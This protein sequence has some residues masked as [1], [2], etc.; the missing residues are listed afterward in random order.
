[1]ISEHFGRG[2]L[3]ELLSLLTFANLL[4]KEG[5]AALRKSHFS[6]VPV[7]Q[8]D[9]SNYYVDQAESDADALIV[10]SA[11]AASQSFDL[12][13]NVAEYIDI[14]ALL[15]ALGCDTTSAAYNIGKM[16]FL[17][18]LQK[19]PDLASGVALFSNQRVNCSLL[20]IVAERF[21]IAVHGGSRDDSLDGLRYKRFANHGSGII[22]ILKTG[23]G[24][25]ENDFEDELPTLTPLH[26]S[27]F[28]HD[29]ISDAEI[30]TE[31]QP[32]PSKKLKTN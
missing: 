24:K 12:V 25:K 10:R 1:M 3:K 16:K 32:D 23:A 17:T 21:F 6:P 9:P 5:F 13:T 31:P 20:S 8:K 26:A 19:H 15:T 30:N 22:M 2:H 7:S 14:L 4:I 11:L 29:T 27:S 28:L 18:T